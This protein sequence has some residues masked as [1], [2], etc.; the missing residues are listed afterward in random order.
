[1]SSQPSH[2]RPCTRGPSLRPYLPPL[3]LLPKP[4][5]DRKKGQ[6]PFFHIL[7]CPGLLV[8]LRS[9]GPQTW[10]PPPLPI[11]LASTAFL[12]RPCSQDQPSMRVPT[13]ELFEDIDAVFLISASPGPSPGT[14]RQQLVERKLEASQSQPSPSW[15]VWCL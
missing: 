9:P 8:V 5:L 7:L 14:G 6:W 2:L 11:S 13:A 1:M 15:R 10:R 4:F 12:Q 3:S